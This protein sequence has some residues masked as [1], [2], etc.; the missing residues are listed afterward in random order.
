MASKQIANFGD[1]LQTTLPHIEKPNYVALLT[2][3]QDYPGS[4]RLVKKSRMK[5]SSG[6]S[7]DWRI[8]I[9]SG[10]S[11]ANVA[12]TDHDH[13]AINDG[14]ISATVP[15]RKSKVSYAFYDEEIT[16]NREPWKLVELIKA[17]EN[18]AMQD[19]FDLLEGNIWDFPSAADV[20][21]P[22]G[23]PYWVPKSATE[24]FTGGIP[25]GYS[26][27]AG[28]SPTTYPRLKSYGGQYSAVTGDDFVLM[29]R[30]MAKRTMFRPPVP[31]GRELTTGASGRGYFANLNT[32]MK[33]E[34]YAD[35]RN[36]NLGRDLDSDAATFRNAEIEWVPWLDDDTTDPFYQIDFEAFGIYVLGD[37]WLRRTVLSPYPG[38]RNVSAVFLDSMY[39][40][41]CFNRRMC[42]VLATGTSYPS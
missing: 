5:V 41:V 37:W 19:W 4:K 38:Q 21:T 30:K 9:Q 7:C 25:T 6:T 35:S 34:N 8:Q 39:A 18:A 12:V 2:D 42:G 10:S 14:F 26:D 17:R 29:A 27:V 20:L 23:I 24:G 15:W 33:Y 40:F 31:N 1:L 32:I 16:V 22:L 13:A 3:K 11:A 36:D 28:Q